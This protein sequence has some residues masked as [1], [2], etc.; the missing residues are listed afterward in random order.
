MFSICCFV[1]VSTSFSTSPISSIVVGTLLLSGSP[2]WLSSSV[3][4]FGLS[5]VCSRARA[6]PS[7]PPF[8]FTTIDDGG[9]GSGDVDECPEPADAGVP[10]RSCLICTSHLIT[11][12]IDPSTAAP[13]PAAIAGG[14]AGLSC[15]ICTTSHLITE[16]SLLP[17][18]SRRSRTAVTETAGGSFPHR[19]VLRGTS[20]TFG[21]YER[22]NLSVSDIGTTFSGFWSSGGSWLSA[23]MLPP[24]E[25][26]S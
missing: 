26:V 4:S 11:D 8:M 23:R 5:P 2:V 14:V 19:I 15:L 3:T 21:W 18:Y 9:G 12:R 24:G 13:P 22:S 16:R 10:E 1:S 17:S 25:I 6:P 20:A 7:P